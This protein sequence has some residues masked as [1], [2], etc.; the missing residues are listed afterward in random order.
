MV[1][2]KEA[3]NTYVSAKDGNR[4][5]LIADAFR[6][7]AELSMELK[8]DS[9]SFP[10]SAI[11]ADGI[12]KVLVSQFAQQ[13]ENVY[14]F[15]IGVPPHDQPSFDCVWLV[16]M[17]EKSTAAARVGFGRYRWHYDAVARKI[18][19]LCITIEQM[20]TLPSDMSPQILSWA[21]GLP[22]PWCPPDL[23]AR[24]APL[25]A[26]IQ[27]IVDELQRLADSEAV[28]PDTRRSFTQN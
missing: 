2:F 8:T 26:P 25:L 18:S 6:P 10:G 24:T 16:C 12:A 27:R 15:C 22:Y 5:H 14:T 28:E 21:R 20:H 11:G 19:G 9:I 1:S 17:T 7:D 23:P 3:I 4:P 13:Y